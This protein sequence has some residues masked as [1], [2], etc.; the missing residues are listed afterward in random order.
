V[1][2]LELIG[3]SA[4]GDEYAA[5]RLLVEG[6]RIVAADAPGLERPLV[7]LSLLEAAAVPGETLAA[8][9]L[10]NAIAPVFVA[11]HVTGRVAVAM[12]GGVDSAVALLRAGSN[13]IGV[14]LRLW[15]DPAGPSAERASSPRARRAIALAFHTSRSTCEKRSAPKSCSRSSTGMH[16]A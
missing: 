7:G 15:L 1:P 13:A 10:A 3:D 11:P 6:D 5:V 8:D 4:R 9:A 12:S 16:R 2:P 14:T